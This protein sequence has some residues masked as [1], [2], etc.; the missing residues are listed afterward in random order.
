MTEID[1]FPGAGKRFWHFYLLSNTSVECLLH[2][3][4]YTPHLGEFEAKTRRKI[5]WAVSMKQEPA[6][7]IAVPPQPGRNLR[8]L[9]RGGRQSGPSLLNGDKKRV[10]TPARTLFRQALSP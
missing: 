9:Y 1:S 7:G 2:R 8:H 3:F 5:L 6:E 10:L 4:F